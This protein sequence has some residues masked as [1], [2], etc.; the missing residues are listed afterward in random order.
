MA[1]KED[2]TLSDYKWQ[3][4]HDV[5]G[6]WWLRLTD[7]DGIIRYME[8]TNNRYDGAMCRALHDPIEKMSPE[9]RIKAQ[10]SGDRDFMFLQ[11][12]TIMAQKHNVSLYN[13]FELLQ[14][15]FALSLYKDIIENGETFIN[16]AGGK[17]HSLEHDQFV[18]RKNLVFPDYAV[19]D[20]RIKRFNGG[21]HFYAYVGDAQLRDGGTLKWNSYAEAYNFAVSVVG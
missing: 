14:Q 16:C 18:Y 7:I 4:V 17:T 9:D 15:E 1:V 13:G 20:I 2:K 19:N 11:A 6:G 10:I 3:F 5:R 21:Q 12:G 8:S